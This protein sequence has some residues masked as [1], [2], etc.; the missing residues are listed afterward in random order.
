MRVISR[1]TCIICAWATLMPASARA[2]PSIS[3]AI[4]D[5]DPPSPATLHN[6]DTV[7]V[8]LK[9]QSDVPLA[10]WVRPYYRG[11]PAQAMTSPSPIYPAGQAE[12]FGW[13][14]FR[15]AGTVDEIHLQAAPAGQRAIPTVDEPELADFT[16]DGQSGPM[17]SP[18]PWAAP[19]QKKEAAAEERGYQNYMNAPLGVTGFIALLI[20]GVL[21]IGALAAT[22][23]WPLWGV[24]RWHG[25]WRAFAALPLAVVGWHTLTITRDLAV[26][27]TS[28][29]LLPFE[30]IELAVVVAPY[31]FIVWLRRR[32]ALRA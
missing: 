20:F 32:S 9:Y 21:V 15:G 14:A 2:D 17:H 25:K 16:W 18:A 12:A 24:L 7:Y 10:I 30:Y 4:I 1:L 27:S 31:M 13:F 23:L 5:T 8:R 3:M 26:D 11:V 28:H 19:W 29:N 22:F 6:G